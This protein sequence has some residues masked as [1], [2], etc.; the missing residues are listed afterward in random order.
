MPVSDIGK[1]M[2]FLN[3]PANFATVRSGYADFTRQALRGRGS[4][5]RL[6]WFLDG[7]GRDSPVGILQSVEERLS[8][9]H[10]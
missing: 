9:I 5:D 4:G 10:I 1:T 2:A 3:E 7:S 8:L 6:G